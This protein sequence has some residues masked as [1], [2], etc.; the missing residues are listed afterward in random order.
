MHAIY[1]LVTGQQTLSKIKI[2][3]VQTSEMTTKETTYRAQKKIFPT[4][5]K[6]VAKFAQA[7]HAVNPISKSV[8]LLQSHEI[9]L[10]QL[11]VF[12]E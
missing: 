10:L 2:V 9:N 11:A 7:V 1:R 12:G 5:K 3:P 6:S 8:I 4:K